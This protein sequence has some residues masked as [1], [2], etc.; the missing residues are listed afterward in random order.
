MELQLSIKSKFTLSDANIPST[1]PIILLALTAGF[2]RNWDWI[3]GSGSGSD[4]RH[5]ENYTYIHITI[6]T[7][8]LYLLNSDSNE[9][10]FQFLSRILIIKNFDLLWIERL[11]HNQIEILKNR[12][13]K[14]GMN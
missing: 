13:F 11:S 1:V 4:L 12:Y 3:L 9:I 10:I 5:T 7:L 2:F 6:C 8:Y 14:K